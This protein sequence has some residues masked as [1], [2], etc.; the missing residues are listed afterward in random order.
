LRAP[1]PT[2]TCAASKIPGKKDCARIR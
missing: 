2:Y 1:I